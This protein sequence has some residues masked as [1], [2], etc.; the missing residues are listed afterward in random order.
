[1]SDR[2]LTSRCISVADNNL[3]G[4]M[5]KEIVGL[6]G[7]LRL[8]VNDEKFGPALRTISGNLASLES[9]SFRGSS[10]GRIP[11]EIGLLTSLTSL[12]LSA[13]TTEDLTGSLPTELGKLALLQEL[14]VLD[15]NLATHLPT[16]L[17][18]LTKL[19]T[20]SL[21]TGNTGSIAGSIPSEV[22]A[23]SN[24][25]VLNLRGVGSLIWVPNQMGDLSNLEVLDLEDSFFSRWHGEEV[26]VIPSVFGSLMNLKELYLRTC[27]EIKSAS[28]EFA[29]SVLFALH[30]FMTALTISFSIFPQTT[31]TY[32][33]PFLNPSLTW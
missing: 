29:F 17:F 10:K 31:I 6:S 9:L 1:M 23:L 14:V 16:E 12:Y 11:S 18:L 28:F 26:E 19:T 33:A 15:H 27:H 32:A 24:L 5:P 22:G 13:P 21:S 20:L 25:R 8:D 4:T 7:L 30:S 3:V 2:N